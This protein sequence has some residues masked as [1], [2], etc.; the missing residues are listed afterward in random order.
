MKKLS[1]L[2]SVAALA[3]VL[4]GCGTGSDPVAPNAILDS[5]PPQ[6]P[7]GLTQELNTSLVRVLEWTAN[8][9]PDLAGYQIYQ[10]SPDPSRD[11]AYV[12]VA[13]VSATTTEW[14]LPIVDDSEITW[15]R[16]RALDQSGNRS[17]ESVAAQVILLPESPGQDTPLDDPN[18][19][20]P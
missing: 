16:L 20:R 18:P 19:V 6:A 9:E 8:S 11:N 5:A 14:A 12:L 10:Y 15:M 13:T 2:I 1:S 4:A 3:A 7:S 17:A